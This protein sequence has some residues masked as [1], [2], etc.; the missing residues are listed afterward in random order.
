[1]ANKLLDRKIANILKTGA[2]IVANGNS[3]CMLQLING[4]KERKLSIRVAHPITLLAEAYRQREK[5]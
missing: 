4:M 1:M 3:G 2:E 5:R